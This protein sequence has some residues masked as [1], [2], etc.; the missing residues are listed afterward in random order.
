LFGQKS[1]RDCGVPGNC[2][3]VEISEDAVI[4]PNHAYLECVRSE[5]GGVMVKVV[6][7]S[8]SLT[9]MQ[10]GQRVEIGGTVLKIE[11]RRRHVEDFD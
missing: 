5:Q 2:V 11:A 1:N 8:G 3:V 7:K 4:Q 6:D 9:F 10:N